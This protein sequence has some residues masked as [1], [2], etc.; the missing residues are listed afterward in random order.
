M[1]GRVHSRELKLEVCR[2]IAS[3]EKR[4]AQVCREHKLSASLPQRW[5][6]E[7]ERRG[8]TALTPGPDSDLEGLEATVAELDRPSHA[9]VSSPTA[10]SNN[11]IEVIKLRVGRAGVER[12]IESDQRLVQAGSL[13]LLGRA[14][15]PGELRIAA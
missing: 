3:G 10:T 14:R 4:P 2:Q 8:G 15:R 7:D 13:A 9:G 1:K 11:H 6:K 12:E 5:R